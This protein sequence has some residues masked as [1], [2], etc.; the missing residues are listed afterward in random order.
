MAIWC[1][2]EY[3]S[4][5]TYRMQLAVNKLNCRADDWCI[6]VSKDKAS[7]TLFF[8]SPK[9]NARAITLRGI[10]LPQDNKATYFGVTF[11]K[12]LTWNPHM[13]KAETKVRQKMAILCKLAGTTWGSW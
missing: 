10:P 9:Q 13:S 5:T 11:D 2:E 4:T 7:T 3:A 8:L 12:M 1:K 6:D